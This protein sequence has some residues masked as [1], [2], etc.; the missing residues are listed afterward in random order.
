LRHRGVVAEIFHVCIIPRFGV[1]VQEER[2][3]D[4]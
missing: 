1:F 3:K 4:Q 2:G